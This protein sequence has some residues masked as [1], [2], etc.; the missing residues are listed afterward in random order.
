MFRHGMLREALE[1][2]GNQ[3]TDEASALELSGHAPRLVESDP[4]NLKV[5][6]PRDLEWPACC[7]AAEAYLR[8]RAGG[9][10]LEAVGVVAARAVGEDFRRLFQ[11]GADL[12]VA[13]A[14]AGQ[15]SESLALGE[16]HLRERLGET[17]L[18]AGRHPLHQGHHVLGG[19]RQ[20]LHVLARQGDLDV[21]QPMQEFP[22]FRQHLI[23]FR[24]ADRNDQTD[25]LGCTRP[26]DWA[27]PV[28]AIRSRARIG[29]KRCMNPPEKLP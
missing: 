23:P 9:P 27:W 4:G 22:H 17:F 15:G 16:G 19:D 7:W 6:Y 3:V 11:G 8:V 13:F 29:M 25:V 5:T 2:A 10:H 21:V 1:K 14:D 26:E 20:P 18:E 28:E 12:A 24:R